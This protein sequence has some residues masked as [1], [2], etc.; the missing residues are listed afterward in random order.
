MVYGGNERALEAG[1]YY[2]L[3]PSEATTIQLGPTLSGIRHAKGIVEEV[4]NNSVFATASKS[5]QTAYNLLLDNKQLIQNKTT[6]FESYFLNLF[7]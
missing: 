6:Q 7:N 1:R 4:L 2:Y 3:Y 5:A